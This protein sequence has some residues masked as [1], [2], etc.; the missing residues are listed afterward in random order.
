MNDFML[1]IEL[2]WMNVSLTHKSFVELIGL[3]R[4]TWFMLKILTK[5]DDD[6]KMYVILREIT[7]QP[8]Y[9]V[10]VKCQNKAEDM[11]I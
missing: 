7:T 10:Y 2:N 8:I 3:Y 6:E 4:K 11:M 9:R 5:L 1:L